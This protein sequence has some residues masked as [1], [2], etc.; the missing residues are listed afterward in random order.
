MEE[1]E[2]EKVGGEATP[3][4]SG[5]S[6]PS[7]SGGHPHEPAPHLLNNFD[8]ALAHIGSYGV[9]QAAVVGLLWLP[10]GAG[11]VIVLLWS[12]TGLEPK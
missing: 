12:F 9:W 3:L 10:A 2:E 4:L 6:D 7:A 1:E 8:Q 5:R 11:G